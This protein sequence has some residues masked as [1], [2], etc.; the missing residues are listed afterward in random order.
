MP[1]KLSMASAENIASDTTKAVQVDCPDPI[2]G[3]KNG[4]AWL[5]PRG[6]SDHISTLT[7]GRVAN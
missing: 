2:D 6:G 5:G 3:T 4:V 7:H 1:M